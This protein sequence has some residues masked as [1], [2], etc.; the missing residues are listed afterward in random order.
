MTNV[1]FPQFVLE[2]GREV[3]AAARTLGLEVARIPPGGC[4]RAASSQAA[5]EH[6]RMAQATAPILDS[7][8]RTSCDGLAQLW[9]KWRVEARPYINGLLYLTQHRIAFGANLDLT[10][11]YGR[12]VPRYV[13]KSDRC[14]FHCERR[15]RL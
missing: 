1:G 14:V 9:N 5:A 11:I 6:K 13:A 2:M 12:P 8:I 10:S 4:P 7:T 3:Q 15:A